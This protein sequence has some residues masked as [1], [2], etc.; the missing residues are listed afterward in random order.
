[1][2][3]HGARQLAV[4]DAQCAAGGVGIEAQDRGDTRRGAEGAAHGGAEE[5]QLVA[6]CA[7]DGLDQVRNR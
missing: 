6:R 3:L 2:G 4:G 7:T 5:A 1:M